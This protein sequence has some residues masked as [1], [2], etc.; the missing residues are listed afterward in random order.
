MAN[1]V[2]AAMAASLIASCWGVDRS[3]MIEEPPEC[4]LYLPPATAETWE[5][6]IRG[7]ETGCM[8][9][10]LT[11]VPPTPIETGQ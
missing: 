7:R 11:P 6:A 1:A 5:L 10:M 2:P 3:G 9:R 4:V 8:I